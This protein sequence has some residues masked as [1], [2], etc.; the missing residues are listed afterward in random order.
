MI[1]PSNETTLNWI[2]CI[3]N[4]LNFPLFIGFIYWNLRMGNWITG[5]E[6]RVNGDGPLLPPMP[7]S[8]NNNNNNFTFKRSFNRWQCQNNIWN[9]HV[10]RFGLPHLRCTQSSCIHVSMF[11]HAIVMPRYTHDFSH[12]W[13]HILFTGQLAWPF[14]A[15]ILPSTFSIIPKLKLLFFS[16]RVVDVLQQC[17]TCFIYV[18]HRPFN[19]AKFCGWYLLVVGH[20]VCT[21]CV[22][23]FKPVILRYLFID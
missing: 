2:N 7:T 4:K 18:S 6:Y 12:N 13:C 20:I 16:S 11:S 1:I 10:T 14:N 3:D 5:L 23:E 21:M 22:C 9:I 17:V 15:T 19:A 8:T